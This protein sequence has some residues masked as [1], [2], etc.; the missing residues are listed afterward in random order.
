MLTGDGEHFC[1]G[2]DLTALRGQPEKVHNTFASC[3]LAWPLPLKCTAH[4]VRT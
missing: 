4:V 1:S 3:F 2:L